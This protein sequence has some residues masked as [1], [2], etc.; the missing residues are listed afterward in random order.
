MMKVVIFVCVIGIALAGVAKK[1]RV[2]EPKPLSD[3]EPGSKEYDHEA[4]LGEQQAA[5]FDELPQEESQRRLGIIADRID[6]NKDG[7]VDK[8]ELAAWIKKAQT[9]Y[10]EED[11]ATQIQ[12]MDEDKDGQIHWD[13]Y[14][15]ST[16]GHVTEDDMKEDEENHGFSYKK[17]IARDEKRWKVANLDN[18][19]YLS[20]EEFQSFLHPEEF[21]HMR[22]VVLDETFT[23]ID[24]NGDGSIS[25]E[26]YIGDMY[27]E[28]E[29]GEEPEWV[30]TE[31][32]QFVAHRD[33]DKDGKLNKEEVRSWILPD[34]YD[35]VEAETSH[36]MY[37]ADS[38]KDEVLT[39]EEIL[40]HHE[41]FV[42]SQV[43]NWGDDLKRHDEF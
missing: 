22:D 5:E 4:F 8:E 18:N 20:V 38:D 31:R 9:R 13:E 14:Y 21:S 12:N 30:K 32:E 25:L 36:L 43:T 33:A 16:Y 24:K 19:D 6:S 27:N 11:A 17:M 42:G 41:T 7:K 26:E 10:V 37:E 15:K 1:N 2:V 34:G 3:E 35:A 29:D 28:E 23:D 40:E 39:K